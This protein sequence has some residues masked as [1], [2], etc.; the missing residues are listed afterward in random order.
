MKPF[1]STTGD[2]E[3]HVSLWGGAGSH[4]FPLWT[5][6][7][8]SDA[9]DQKRGRHQKLAPSKGIPPLRI[10]SLPPATWKTWD[11]SQRPGFLR[12]RVYWVGVAAGRAPPFLCAGKGLEQ[13]FRKTPFWPHVVQALVLCLFFF[14]F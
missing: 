14:F 8:A 13:T 10:L 3:L 4:A 9:G 1:I 5:S 6:Q 11:G 2:T 12:P 7:H